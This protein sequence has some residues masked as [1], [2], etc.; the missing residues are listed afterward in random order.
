MKSSTLELNLDLYHPDNVLMLAQ[1]RVLTWYGFDL[2]M[3]IVRQ[4]QLPV[5]LQLRDGLSA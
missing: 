2:L 1:Q 4:L 3:N 5:T